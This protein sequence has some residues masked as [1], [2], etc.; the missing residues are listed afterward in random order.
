MRKSL[1]SGKLE[2]P[3]LANSYEHLGGVYTQLKDYPKA[4]KCYT[5]ILESK[6]VALG[7]DHASTGQTHNTLGC[8]LAG[9]GKF[10]EALLHHY[11]ALTIFQNLNFQ[12]LNLTDVY[13]YLI[14]S[15]YTEITRCLK[16]LHS[17][18]LFDFKKKIHR[19]KTYYFCNKC[20]VVEPKAMLKSC[21]CRRAYYCFGE[22]CQ[23]LDEEHKKICIPYIAS[24]TPKQ[25]NR[26]KAEGLI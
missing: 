22:F 25:L 20:K 11:K 10:K 16:L 7:P 2:H 24:Y 9:Q 17:P 8:C 12:G 13:H 21:V 3:D 26:M 15:T 6:K 23:Q 18:L 14:H 19:K 1:F 4:F 5:R